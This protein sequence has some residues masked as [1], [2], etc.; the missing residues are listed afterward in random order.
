MD[1]ISASES[2]LY[3]NTI[4]IIVEGGVSLSG[5]VEAVQNNVCRGSSSRNH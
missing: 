2:G 5:V 3:L 4:L 1:G